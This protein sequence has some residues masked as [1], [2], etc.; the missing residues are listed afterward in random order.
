M[1]KTTKFIIGLLSLIILITITFLYFKSEKDSEKIKI[2]YQETSLYQHI[3]IA[4]EKGFFQ[5][6]NIEVELIPFKSANQMMQALITGDIDIL[7][8]TNLQVALTV[9]GK[10]KGKFKMINFLVWEKE[11]YPDYVITKKGLGIK[12]LKDLEGKTLGLHPGSAVKAFASAILKLNYVNEDKVTTIELE[13]SLMQ[14]SLL[15]NN[16]QAVYCMDPAATNILNTGEG[17]IIMSNPMQYI[18]PAPTPISGTAISSKLTNEKPE[19]SKRIIEAIN[20]GIDYTR[21]SEHEN[22]ILLMIEKYTPI[23]TEIMKK[24]NP[25]EYW[26]SNEIDIN[27]VQQ[28][29]DKFL[30]LGIVDKPIQVSEIITK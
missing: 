7:G 6:E 10:E 25:S 15:S 14:S 9:E 19:L 30:E 26:K 3:F 17:E 18:F 11:S 2:G 16:V 8:L 29:S 13:P 22:E 21:N 23:K 24:M 4:Q 1:S 28:L 5:D 12:S 20:K 27:R